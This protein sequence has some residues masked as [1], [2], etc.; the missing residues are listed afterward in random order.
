MEFFTNEETFRIAILFPLYNGGTMKKEDLMNKTEKDCFN[1]NHKDFRHSI[2]SDPNKTSGRKKLEW[3]IQQAYKEGYISRTGHGMYQ[4]TE[5]GKAYVEDFSEKLEHNCFDLDEEL[6]RS[7]QA[8]TGEMGLVDFFG[9]TDLSDFEEYTCKPPG[10]ALPEIHIAGRKI[11]IPSLE[12]YSDRY[13]ETEEL[14]IISDF[15]SPGNSL[16]FNQEGCFEIP[17]CSSSVQR[18][19]EQKSNLLSPAEYEKQILELK[20]LLGFP[21]YDLPDMFDDVDCPYEL[22]NENDQRHLSVEAIE[23][24]RNFYKQNQTDIKNRQAKEVREKIENQKQ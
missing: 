16:C 6:R 11:R 17:V 19:T 8:F 24:I 20:K 7:T 23:K 2:P 9:S 4:I 15:L 5:K 21:D 1:Q 14:L 12:E 13:Y 3:A 18:S 10:K 22:V